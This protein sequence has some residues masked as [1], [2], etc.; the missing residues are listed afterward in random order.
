MG[1]CIICGAY[2]FTTKDGSECPLCYSD[3]FTTYHDEYKTQSVWFTDLFKKTHTEAM[4]ALEDA[5]I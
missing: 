5:S 4:R 2:A 1:N 3:Q